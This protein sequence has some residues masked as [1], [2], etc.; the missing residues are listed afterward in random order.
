MI[1]ISAFFAVVAVSL[2]GFFAVVGPTHAQF[3][4]DKTKK[5]IEGGKNPSGIKLVEDPTVVVGRVIAAALQLIGV[6]FFILML[7][8]GF[9][10]MTA[11]GNSEQVEKARDMI[12]AAIIGLVIV[13]AA[14]A[15]T[16]YLTKGVTGTS[17]EQQAPPPATQ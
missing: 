13:T 5:E 4:L 16:D 6:V 7:Y 8:A 10:W 17:A 12:I 1:R 3:G 9:L 14:Y 2:F 11:R 15:I